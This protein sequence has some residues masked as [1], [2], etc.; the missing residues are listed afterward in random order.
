MDCSR[1][2]MPR[3][4]NRLPI[5]AKGNSRAICSGVSI[6]SWSIE[7]TMISTRCAGKR[8]PYWSKLETLLNQSEKS[9]LKSLSRSDLQQLSLLYRQTAADLAA[10]REDRASV[11]FARY[12]NQLLVRAHNTIYSGRRASPTAIFS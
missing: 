10:I 11:H 1:V 6:L 4:R 5:P 8:K 7:S 9:G 12:V 2:S 3:A